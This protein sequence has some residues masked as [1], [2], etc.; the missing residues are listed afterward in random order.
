MINPDQIEEWIHEVEQRP[1]SAGLIIEYISRR[2]RDLT[3][4]NEELLAENIS[5]RMGKKVEEY[6]SRIANHCQPGIPARP[7]PPAN[8]W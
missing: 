6:E 3:A 2:L 5:L 7:A 8:G 1:S 4:R